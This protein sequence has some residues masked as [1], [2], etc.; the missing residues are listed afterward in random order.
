MASFCK[1]H[2]DGPSSVAEICRA[3]GDGVDTMA[4]LSALKLPSGLFGTRAFAD[5]CRAFGDGVSTIAL[6]SGFRVQAGLFET[7]MPVVTC[8]AFGDGVSTIADQ[9][10]FK[11]LSP[12]GSA[13]QTTPLIALERAR[14]CEKASSLC[15][16]Q[17]QITTTKL[18]LRCSEYHTGI[19]SPPADPSSLTWQVYRSPPPRTAA[20]PDLG[21]ACS[22]VACPAFT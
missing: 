18:A 10:G 20:M 6:Q 13:K 22:V 16:V 2:V 11:L 1:W 14:N 15:R 7:R 9:S 17:Y 21:T 12:T 4:N 5:I 8:R 3:L 19:G